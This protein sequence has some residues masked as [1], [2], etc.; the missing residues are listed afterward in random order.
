MTSLDLGT[1]E[2]F[3]RRQKR[4]DRPFAQWTFSC[5]FKTWIYEPVVDARPN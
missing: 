2:R 4:S 1:N 3:R 5:I